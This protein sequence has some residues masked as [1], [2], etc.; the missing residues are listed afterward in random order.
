[1]FNFMRQSLFVEEERRETFVEA[2]KVPRIVP[3]ISNTIFT[4]ITKCPKKCLLL[5]FPQHRLKN[6]KKLRL[7]DVR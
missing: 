4:L 5:L 3:G 6:E 2:K 7:T 1:M